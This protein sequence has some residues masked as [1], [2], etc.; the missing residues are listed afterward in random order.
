MAALNGALFGILLGAPTLRLTGDYFA[1]V[2][3][4]FSE[5]VVLFLTNEIWLTRGPNGIPGIQPVTL[6]GLELTQPQQYYFVIFAILLL[7]IIAVRRVERSRVGRAWFAI[8]ENELAASACGINIVSYKVIAFALSASIAAIGGAFF[9]HMSRFISPDPFRFW[10]SIFILCL[11]VLG[12]MGSV[13]GVL[14]GTPILFPLI[15]I[16]RESLTTACQLGK[17]A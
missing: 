8:R 4:G 14:V 15:N 13:T 3:F 5:L 12:G 6:F 11:I 10:E 17:R 16:L 2:T 7:V 9:A 1:I